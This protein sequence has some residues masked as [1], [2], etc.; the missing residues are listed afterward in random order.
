M[1]AVGS[2][3][4]MMNYVIMLFVWRPSGLLLFVVSITAVQHIVSLLR[5]RLCSGCRLHGLASVLVWSCMLLS[6]VCKVEVAFVI[7]HYIVT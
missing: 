3:M 7:F 6:F 5:L 1:S 4:K 2:M